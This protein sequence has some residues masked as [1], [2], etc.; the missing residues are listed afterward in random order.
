M[1]TNIATASSS[2]GNTSWGETSGMSRTTRSSGEASTSRTSTLTPS[3]ELLNIDTTQN[4]I[5]VNIPRTINNPTQCLICESTTGLI[6]V[7]ERAYLDTFIT[8][9]VLI[10]SGSMCCKDHLTSQNTFTKYDMDNIEIVSNTTRLTGYEVSLTL[11]RIRNATQTSRC[12]VFE[13]YSNYNQNVSDDESIRFTGLNLVQ[14]DT[15][16]KSLTSMRSTSN[17]D[18]PQAVSTY[19]FWLKSGLDYRTI[20]T[21]FG[22]DTFQKVGHYCDQVRT[23]MLNDFVPNN[24]GVNHLTR[25]EW[26]N[27]NTVLAKKLFDVSDKQLTLIADG[28][29]VYCQKSANNTLQRRTYST[30]K[31]RHLGKPFVICTPN[32]KIVD[33]YGLFDATKNDAQILSTLHKSRSDLKSLLKPN[34]HIVLDR[35]FRDIIPEL[36]NTY[37]LKTHMPTC[38]P[39]H[40]KQFTVQQAND[41]RI[42]TKV[43]W[44]VETING[45]LKTYRANDKV[46]KNVTMQNSLY[47]L[48]ITAA[49]INAF[50]G[51]FGT[52]NECNL[53]IATKMLSRKNTQNKLENI[54]TQ[55]NIDKYRKNYI[56]LNIN[57]IP[58]FPKLDYNTIHNNITFGS[59]QLKQAMGY[60]N[61]NFNNKYSG[62][63]LYSDDKEIFD[64][65]TR[66]IRAKIQSRH[67]KAKQYNTFITYNVKTNNANSISNWICS[68]KSGKRTVGCCSHV[69][70]LIY[71]LS[72]VKYDD[73]KKTLISIKKIFPNY[74]TVNSSDESESEILNPDDSDSSEMEIEQATKS[75]PKLYPDLPDL[76]D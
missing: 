63:E 43:R 37:K 28:T 41:S 61:E 26:I 47:D 53:E 58:D 66:L 13:R 51:D 5:I 50:N 17:R 23:A 49:L 18:V 35:G 59:Y 57:S 15:L 7:P 9:N 36:T 25:Q 19:L 42:V 33:V 8:N 27:E 4:T 60:I 67:S 39:S 68:C 55:T 32:G 76:E 34:D 44:V 11:D 75:P 71:Y 40:Q 21:I 62:I 73:P 30:Q 56:K 24:L 65:N 52:S 69:A 3:T 6:E 31:S 46:H 38:I 45:R 72:T 16:V 12:T 22:I 14:F 2:Y 64:K 20:S 54:F 74:A 48:K 10:P 70:S 1:F 29:Y